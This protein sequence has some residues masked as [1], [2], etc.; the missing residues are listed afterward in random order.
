MKLGTLGAYKS[1]EDHPTD[2]RCGSNLT[3]KS[4]RKSPDYKWAIPFINGF[5]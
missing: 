4:D 3:R 1:Y 2:R 5:V